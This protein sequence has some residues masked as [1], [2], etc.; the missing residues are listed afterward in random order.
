MKTK[1]ILLFLIFTS[2]TQAA[3]IKHEALTPTFNEFT[4]R[5]VCEKL[6]SKNFE[7]MEAKS[8]NEIDCMGKVFAA[9]EFCKIT[10]K[11]DLTLTRAIVDDKTKTVRC[12]HSSSVMLS[13][14]C[15]SRDAKYCL[16]PQQGCETL[17]GMY[18]AK[19]ETAH[20]SF[21]ENKDQKNINCY[22]AKALGDDLSEIY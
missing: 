9:I 15:D 18:A 21:V 10:D 6:G 12:E 5:E 16:D 3:L 4:F 22:F 1:L 8:I 17:K 7:L 11:N 13:I 19:L 2:L 20:Y 14:S